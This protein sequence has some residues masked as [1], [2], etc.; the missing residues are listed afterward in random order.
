MTLLDLPHM[1][2]G[3]LVFIMIV[4]LKY[5]LKDKDY[6]G[7]KWLVIGGLSLLLQNVFFFINFGSTAIISWFRDI[8]AIVTFVI[9]A[10]GSIQLIIEFFER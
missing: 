4:C 1:D 5:V 3:L 2:L 9:M 8:S 7:F 10:I 6:K